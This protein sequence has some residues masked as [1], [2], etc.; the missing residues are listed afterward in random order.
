MIKKMMLIAVT[1]ICALFACTLGAQQLSPA[2]VVKA[3]LNINEEDGLKGVFTHM[4]KSAVSIDKDGTEEPFATFMFASNVMDLYLI[5]KKERSVDNFIKLAEAMV[6]PEAIA[7]QKKQGKSDQQIQQTK[8]LIAMLK[9]AT[10]AERR[11]FEAALA[12]P[13]V[14]QGFHSIEQ[15]LKAGQMS[16]KTVKVLDEKINGDTATVTIESN[17]YSADSTTGVISDNG[18]GTIVYTLK[19]I[20]GAWKI[21]RI[22]KQSE[23][24]E[25][26]AEPA[27]KVKVSS[28][29]LDVVKLYCALD[30]IMDLNKLKQLCAPEYAEYL[31]GKKI[32]D[33]QSITILEEFRD[34]LSVN[35]ANVF[36]QKITKCFAKDD[37]WK[38]L[39]SAI[40]LVDSSVS[41]ADLMQLRT[42]FLFA[43]NNFTYEQKVEFMTKMK[44]AMAESA[45]KTVEESKNFQYR[46]LQ[47][48]GATA[49]VT[50][51]QPVTDPEQ[52]AIIGNEI[53]K[54]ISL[55]MINGQWKITKSEASFVK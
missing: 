2:E 15:T 39:A 51:V 8:Q 55:K 24:A 16:Y 23:K 18:K 53:Q 3:A 29:P 12:S 28:N 14:L 48:N 19:Q 50:V 4:D 34:A 11:Q 26:K 43:L 41:E 32:A 36:T 33:Y 21:V 46:D 17:N 54:K 13:K 40:G 37:V 38:I 9:K 42:L 30:P 20:N 49:T 10:P 35:D 52:I 44:N 27:V 7:F 25:K 22:A 6:S 47:I 5:F 1:A 45:A 31:N